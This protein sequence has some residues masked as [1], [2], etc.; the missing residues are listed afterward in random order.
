MQREN[1]G[2]V[3]KESNRRPAANPAIEPQKL[4]R[5]VSAVLSIR[6]T[7]LMLFDLAVLVI[8]ALLTFWLYPTV[9]GTLTVG[10]ITV[11]LLAATVCIMGT[12]CAGKIYLQVWRYSR[13][14]S[15]LRMM[16]TDVVGGN[17]LPVV[18]LV[19][20]WPKSAAVSDDDLGDREPCGQFGHSLS[21]YLAV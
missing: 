3:K 4:R 18:G 6:K 11:Q 21:V 10:E 1:D 9:L 8:S 5:P 20:A 16:C 17:A 13:T 7:K 14:N 2:F 15:Y 19:A 12:R